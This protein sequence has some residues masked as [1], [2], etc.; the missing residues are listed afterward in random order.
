VERKRIDRYDLCCA[1]S[2][3]ATFASKK[4]FHASDDLKR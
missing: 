4:L 3:D 2:Y 1:A